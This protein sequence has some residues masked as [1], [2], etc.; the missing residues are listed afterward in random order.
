[1]NL[2]ETEPYRMAKTGSRKII[3]ARGEEEVV[4][5]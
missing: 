1:M 3:R 2:P 5:G 4:Y